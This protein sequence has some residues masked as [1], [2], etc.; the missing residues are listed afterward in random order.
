MRA[1]V[2]AQG[3]DDGDDAVVGSGWVD[4]ACGLFFYFADRA[5]L[6]HLRGRAAH[7]Y[8]QEGRGRSPSGLPAN[9]RF[10]PNLLRQ[11]LGR[12]L[13]G[14]AGPAVDPARSDRSVHRTR[15]T[16]QLPGERDGQGVG[17]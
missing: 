6:E 4:R 1:D 15:G 7:R 2:I 8:G 11:E 17:P 16:A 10:P 3:D 5:Q 13:S 9:P 14:R 12:F